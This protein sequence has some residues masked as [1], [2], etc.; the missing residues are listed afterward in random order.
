MK[1]RHKMF[2]PRLFGHTLDEKAAIFGSPMAGRIPQDVI[3]EIMQRADI[4]E[5]VGEYV[6]LKRRGRN[7]FGLCPFHHEDTPSFSVNPEKGIFKCF[8]C[9]KGGNAVG[10]VQEMEHLTFAEAVR[11][12]GDRYHVAIPEKAMSPEEQRLHAERQA[13]LSAHKEA[14]A[15]YASCVDRSQAAR[16][17]MKKRGISPEMAQR[18][19]LGFAPEEDW[20]ALY[21]R[22]HAEGYGDDTLIK[23]GLISKSVKNGRCYDKFHGR[24]IFPIRDHRGT[25]VAFGGRALGEEQPKYLNSQTTPIYNKSNLLYALDLA[26]DSVRQSGQIVIMEG[27]MDVLTAHSFGVTNAVASLGTAFTSEHVRLLNRFAPEDGRKL[28]V[29]LSFDGDAAGQ[30]AA[31]MSL[32]KL[33]GCDFIEPRVLVYPNDLDPDDFLRKYG[34]KGWERLLERYCY[35]RLDYLLKKALERHD[36]KTAAGKG[37]IVAELAPALRATRNLTEYDGFVR[38]LAR[39]LQVSEEAIRA[40]VGRG[41]RKGET[42][43][44]GDTVYHEKR[45]RPGRPANRQLLLLALSNENIFRRAQSELGELFPSTEEE[46]QLI[47]YVESLGGSYDFL[48]SSLF[49]YLDE[50]QEGLRQFLLKL[51]QTEAPQGEADAL[52]NDYIRAIRQRDLADRGKVLQ[53]RIAEAESRGEDVSELLREKMQLAQ[54]AKKL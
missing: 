24:L 25:V 33:A 22:L 15:F 29:L 42:E 20:Q 52:A 47:A 30:K 40:D 37:D 7:W 23:C 41:S 48:P 19:G 32:D 8:G 53:R 11:K 26:A 43:R 21:Q 17:Y 27:Y 18:F 9:G 14:A 46:A 44:R 10:F 13:M 12:L 31:R 36:A 54:E 35:P 16:A 5:I 51:L 4:L 1:K 38:Q 3:D 39:Q 28:Q 2:Y 6:P 45:F 49:N 50:G 34:M